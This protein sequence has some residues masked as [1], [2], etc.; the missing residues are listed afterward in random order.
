M[1]D[2]KRRAFICQQAIA[3]VKKQQEEGVP[4]KGK[5]PLN[6]FLKRKMTNKVDD[7]HKK[8]KVVT[9]STIKVTPLTT[10]LPP[11]P[12]LR[13]G[14]GLMTEHSLISKKSLVLLQEDSQYAIGQLS[15]I[16]KADDYEDLGNHA[17]EAIRETGLFSLTQVCI[18]PSF[19]LSLCYLCF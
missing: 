3:W 16:I 6:P 5:G 14:K 8:P 1:E 17:T 12:R 13:K 19:F 4:P 18:C 15:S 7:P 10:Q 9:R 11:S 2:G